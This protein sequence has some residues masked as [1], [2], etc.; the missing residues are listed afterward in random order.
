MKSYAL[1]II[2]LFFASCVGAKN[3][4]APTDLMSGSAA[5]IVKE[6]VAA[7]HLRDLMI[8]AEEQLFNTEEHRFGEILKEAIASGQL[9][10]DELDTAKW[11]LHD[12]IELNSAGRKASDFQFK[13]QEQGVLTLW[14][15]LPGK[16]LLL[17]IYDPDCGS[18]KNVISQLQ[19]VSERID[20]LAVCVEATEARWQQTRELLPMDWVKAFDCSDILM[21]DSYIIRSMPG[22]Y[23]LDGERNVILKHPKPEQLLNYL[24]K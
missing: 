23:L 21:N 8:L 2:S 22:L 9:T 14:N 1:V 17:V 7:G 11:M 15:Y 24:K 12:V 10:E 13:T 16:P 4:T 3:W 18:C 5:T 6:A 19:N 20:V